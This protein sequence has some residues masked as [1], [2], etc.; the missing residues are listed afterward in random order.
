MTALTKV[1]RRWTT[2]KHYAIL[3]ANCLYVAL[4]EGHVRNSRD[5]DVLPD[6]VLIFAFADVLRYLGLACAFFA[7]ATTTIADPVT[8]SHQ[9]QHHSQ[10]HPDQLQHYS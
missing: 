7:P 2:S 4:K 10:Q 8:R 1:S 5:G 6:T 9:E 3:H